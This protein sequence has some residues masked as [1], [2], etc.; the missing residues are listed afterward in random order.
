MT[1]NYFDT[2]LKLFFLVPQVR[3]VTEI[4]GFYDTLI[5]LLL[6]SDYD[7]D[8]FSNLPMQKIVT[9]PLTGIF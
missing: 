4:I 1:L 8:A 9:D 6:T 7:I 2:S 3:V 5:T